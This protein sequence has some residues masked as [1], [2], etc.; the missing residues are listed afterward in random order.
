MNDSKYVKEA[1]IQIVE[2]PNPGLPNFSGK[3]FPLAIL[4]KLACRLRVSNRI[5]WDPNCRI[6][7]EPVL[8]RILNWLQ[9]G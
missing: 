6:S 3:R 1:V 7:F 9:Q 5:G 8:V 4:S 2:L